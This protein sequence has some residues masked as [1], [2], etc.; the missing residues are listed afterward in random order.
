MMTLYLFQDNQ[1]HCISHDGYIQIGSFPHSVEEHMK[2]NP[3]VDWVVTY[4]L[5]DCFGKR[6]KRVSFQRTEKA[7]EGSPRTDNSVQA[8]TRLERTL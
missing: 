6:Y 1:D 7:N 2:L 3:T 8:Q 5:P 4:W